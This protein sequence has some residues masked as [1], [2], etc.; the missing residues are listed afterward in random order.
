MSSDSDGEEE[1]P[2]TVRS[3][4]RQAQPPP[5]TA[6]SPG[7]TARA[8]S[9][10]QTGRHKLSELFTRLPRAVPLARVAKY[11]ARIPG[12]SG[13]RSTGHFRGRGARGRGPTR[14]RLAVTTSHGP[15]TDSFKGRLSPRTKAANLPKESIQWG[16]SGTQWVKRDYRRQK[17]DYL[18]N[19]GPIPTLPDDCHDPWLDTVR[20]WEKRR[21]TSSPPRIAAATGEAPSTAQQAGE[22]IATSGCSKGAQ[23]PRTPWEEQHSGRMGS[24]SSEEEAHLL[25]TPTRG[26]RTESPAS[27]RQTAST[28]ESEARNGGVTPPTPTNEA[29]LDS[30]PAATSAKKR[31]PP[32]HSPKERPKRVRRAPAHLQEYDLHKLTSDDGEDVIDLYDADG[33]K[34]L[35]GEEEWMDCM[36]F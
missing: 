11:T 4:I 27:G 22:Q 3:I 6:P 23:D 2:R 26:N 9:Q 35:E 13:G 1:T 17:R 28:P 15:S 34:F 33:E 19:K 21:G 31:T 20:E 24:T 25:A 36:E 5:P 10:P 32:S 12:R 14:G 7:A 29:G 16:S 8:L 30:P 18:Y